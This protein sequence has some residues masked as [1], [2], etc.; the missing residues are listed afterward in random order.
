MQAL[1]AGKHAEYLRDPARLASGTGIDDGNAIL[2][3]ILGSKDVSRSV[4]TAAAENTGVDYSVVKKMLPMLAAAVMGAMS[5]QKQTI[6]A[7]NPATGQMDVSSLLGSFLDT[8]RDGSIADDLL[9]AAS[10]LFRG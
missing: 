2:G 1:Q 9:G 5:Q 8:N 4:A 10:K 7:A 3:H 6:S